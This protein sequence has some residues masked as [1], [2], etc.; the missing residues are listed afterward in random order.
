MT[1]ALIFTGMSCGAL[2]VA[3]GLTL[4]GSPR[5][6]PRLSH[7]VRAIC[8]LAGI[9]LLIGALSAWPLTPI[10][11]PILITALAVFPGIQRRHHSHW[12]DLLLILPPLILAGISLFWG[13]TSAEI[14]ME[15]DSFSISVAELTAIVCGGFGVRALGQS[16]RK[17]TAPLSHSEKFVT[18][19]AVTYALLTLLTSSTTLTN[20][21]QQGTMWKGTVYEGRLAGAWLAWSATWFGPRRPLWLRAILTIIA[22]SLL[23]ILAVGW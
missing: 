7:A 23:I 5:Q 2:L 21:W 4:W 15:T 10:S 16:L 19:A 6:V 14:K 17:I 18:P 12:S 3:I 8:W 13:V 20:L 11:Y 9:F 1:T 22:T